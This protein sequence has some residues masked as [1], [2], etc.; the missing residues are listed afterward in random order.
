VRQDDHVGVYFRPEWAFTMGPEYAGSTPTPYCL[1]FMINKSRCTDKDRSVKARV[2][3][4][5]RMRHIKGE[6][7]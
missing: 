6:L 2:P 1:R 4:G 5:A 7:P 3:T